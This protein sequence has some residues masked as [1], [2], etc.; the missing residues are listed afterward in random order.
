ML[1]HPRR[2]RAMTMA[3]DVQILGMIVPELAP[4]I[5]TAGRL[6]A[7]DRWRTTLRMLELLQGPRFE[8][9]LAALLYE[10]V[11]DTEPGEAALV[12]EQ[13]CRR[14]KLSNDECNDVA[15]LVGQREALVGVAHCK[16][17]RLKRLLAKPLIGELM[18]LVRAH[19]VATA[20]SL[21]DV[22][23]C[24]HSLSATP[25]EEINPPP[26]I[27]GDDLKRI[28]ILP[29]PQFKELLDLVRDA[30]LDG[31]ISTPNEALELA[32]RIAGVV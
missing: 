10:L 12:A 21:A 29:G 30:Q 1:V 16:K 25:I 31:L 2:A 18:A 5:A 23:F 24:E 32:R 20:G 15:W 8:L 17:S 13:I 11:F 14:L 7:L 9:A 6:A 4:V 19:A 28:G 3:H 27:T 26:L 22:E